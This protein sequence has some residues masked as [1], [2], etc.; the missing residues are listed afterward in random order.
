M[1]DLKMK[2][3]KTLVVEYTCH[4]ENMVKKSMEGLKNRD[5]KTLDNIIN[6]L[7]PVS[8]NMEVKIDELCTSIIARYQPMAKTLRTVIMILKIN[9]DLERVGDLAVN[10]AQ[11]SLYL[12]DKPLFKPLI[13]LPR[14]AEISLAMLNQA[15]NSFITEDSELARRVCKQDDTVDNLRNQVIRELLTFMMEKPEVIK[16]SLRL[17][18]ISKHLERIADLSTNISEDVVFIVEG[19]IIKHTWE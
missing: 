10:I 5:K 8:N 11:N 18:N 2:E 12:I 1:I 17:M 7:E 6:E 16:P 9:N 4:V 13:D 3:L 14:M 19:K 15:I